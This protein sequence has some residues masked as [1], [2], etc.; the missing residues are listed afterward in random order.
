MTLVCA[1]NSSV[2]WI[3]SIGYQ[4]ALV[5]SHI[6]TPFCVCEK[7]R[8]HQCVVHNIPRATV[9]QIMQCKRVCVCVCGWGGGWC[10]RLLTI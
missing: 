3:R 9:L 10:C 8:V 1:C 7:V 6:V 2:I 4:C 5:Y